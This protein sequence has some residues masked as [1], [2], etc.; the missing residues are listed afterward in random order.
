MQKK[1]IVLIALLTLAACAAPSR[2]IPLVP[3]PAAGQF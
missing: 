3:R 1:L 2:D